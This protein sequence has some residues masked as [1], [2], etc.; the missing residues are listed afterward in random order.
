[1]VDVNKTLSI[2][3]LNISGL[4][5]PSKIVSDYKAT[6]KLTFIIYEI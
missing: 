6:S 2:I 4:N 3:I 5:T 1:M